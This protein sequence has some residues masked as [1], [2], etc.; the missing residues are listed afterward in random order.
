MLKLFIC[1]L[2]FF[3]TM[4]TG[5]LSSKHFLKPCQL[6]PETQNQ[7]CAQDLTLHFLVLDSY[8]VLYG[9]LVRKIAEILKS[10]T[11][12]DTIVPTYWIK[13]G[14]LFK[15][16]VRLPSE[17]PLYHHPSLPPDMCLGSA[18]GMVSRI[19]SFRTRD[20][21]C[22]TIARGNGT[23]AHTVMTCS[24]IKHVN[25]TF[26]GNVHN[27]LSSRLH[28]AGNF[29]I[30]LEHNAINLCCILAKIGFY[31]PNMLYPY[32]ADTPIYRTKPFPPRVPLNRGPTLEMSDSEEDFAQLIKEPN[33]SES[34]DEIN[35][36]HTYS[37]T[38]IYRDARGKGFCPVNRGAQYIGVKY[39]LFPISGEFYPPGKS[40]FRDCTIVQP[41][42]CTVGPLFN[43]TLGGKAEKKGNYGYISC[44]SK[45]DTKPR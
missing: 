29:S 39:R 30:M 13:K 38:P 7:L 26:S 4:E 35:R 20:I 9:V 23:A 5:E 19:G 18:I 36:V 17:S 8:F 33:K 41:Y 32:L 44:T 25:G 11:S 14:A 22:H 42:V 21:L 15:K 1:L 37:R 3:I 16:K 10:L 45:R 6:E 24:F 27:F 34:N 28:R 31:G 2:L 12:T 43:G 40:G